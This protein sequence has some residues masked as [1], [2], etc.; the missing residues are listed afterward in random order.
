MKHLLSY[1]IPE[2]VAEFHS[3]YNHY[4]RINR[5]SNRMKLL[6]NGSP[7]SG[8]YIEQLW[9][10]AF[11]AFGVGHGGQAKKILVLGV[12]GGTVI[13]MLHGFFS[14]AVITGVDIDPLMITI[15]KKYFG[16]DDVA[17]LRLIRSDA[18]TFIQS[19]VKKNKQYDMVI[20]DM[21]FGRVIPKFVT[22]PTFLR[23]IRSTLSSSGCVVINYLRELEYQKQSDKLMRTLQNIFLVVHDHTIFRNRFF[24]VS[25][26]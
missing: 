5:E 9:N 10:S 15:G 21:S 23:R 24:F 12:A 19:T 13:R 4:I 20:L 8:K 6:V 26:V 1:L 7:Q 11:K 2:K 18:N 14:D 22:S 17:G 16:L 25:I 3:P